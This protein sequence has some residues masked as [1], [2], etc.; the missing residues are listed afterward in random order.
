VSGHEQCPSQWEH[1]GCGRPKGH[2]EPHVSA[3]RM[4]GWCDGVSGERRG[5]WT[6]CGE[7]HPTAG[8]SCYAV[9]GH[10]GPHYALTVPVPEGEPTG[11][12]SMPFVEWKTPRA[13][14][15]AR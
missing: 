10:K 8:F 4:S 11:I 15:P 12:R 9:K 13:W 7:V 14:K 2:P 1:A 5:P 3:D 6:A